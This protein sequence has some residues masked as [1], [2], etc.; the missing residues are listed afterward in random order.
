MLSD[1]RAMRGYWGYVAVLVLGAMWWSQ[2][3]GP[4]VLIALSGFVSVYFMFRAPVW[5]GAP[6]RSEGPCRNNAQGIL[7]GCHYQ[8]HKWQKVRLAV[9]PRQWKTLNAGL[10]TSPKVGLATLGAV[11]G[12][13]STLVS[14]TAS[15]VQAVT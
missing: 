11:L 2:A 7:M 13:I 5:C 1:M 4:G 8:Q 9:V 10:W 14:T 3:V 12:I 6:T 15:V